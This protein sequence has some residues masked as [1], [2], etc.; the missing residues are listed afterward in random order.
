ME[1]SCTILLENHTIL[2]HVPSEATPIVQFRCERQK[3]QK[4]RIITNYQKYREN[5]SHGEHSYPFSIYPCVIPDL[6]SEV[7][8]HWHEEMEIILI[9]EGRGIVSVDLEKQVL[10]APAA[11]FIL[12]GQL[13]EICQYKQERM[14]Y[15]NILFHPRLLQSYDNDI[16][17]RQ[18]L[19]PLLDGRLQMPAF[20]QGGDVGFSS[21]CEPLLGCEKTDSP[22][23]VKSYLFLLCSRLFDMYPEREGGAARRE[24]LER[25]KPV[26][27]Y[28]QEHY[29]E[30]ITIADVAGQV[31]FSEAHFMRF[32]KETLGMS[33]V[34]YLKNYRLSRAE[35]MLRTTD[36]SVLEIA[37]DNGFPNVSYFI[38]EFK[39]KYGMTPLKYRSRWET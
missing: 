5:K 8:V 22:L 34:T 18:Y 27:I 19:D 26:L 11:V 9:K 1:E 39:A 2:A 17:D 31:D 13:H 6:F 14:E 33:F 30:V 24:I 28:V 3:M 38:R 21:L 35:E 23:M 37:L 7:R 36:V 10:T 15:E 32:F 4:N 29:S 16:F 12:P 25:L 20:L